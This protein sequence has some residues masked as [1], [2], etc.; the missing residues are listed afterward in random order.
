MEA[1]TSKQVNAILAQA[2]EHA[3][4]LVELLLTRLPQKKATAT[5]AEKIKGAVVDGVTT[6]VGNAVA[7][8]V[9]PLPA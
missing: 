2:M 3:P 1:Q 4:L 5:A 8:V 7:E 6:A 9:K